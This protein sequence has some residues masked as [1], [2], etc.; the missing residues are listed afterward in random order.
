MWKLR[1]VTSAAYV[2][3]VYCIQCHTELGEKVPISVRMAVQPEA[4]SC[5]PAYF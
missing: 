2:A 5:F 3:T 4:G 1:E